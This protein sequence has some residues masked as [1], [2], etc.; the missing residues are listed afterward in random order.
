MY[1]KTLVLF[2]PD[3]VE[4][5][6]IG[7][8]ITFFEE[9]GLKIHAIKMIHATDTQVADHYS[10][11]QDK[12]FFPSLVEFLQSCPIVALV[13][14]GYQSISKVRKIC[15]ATE[16]AKAELASIRGKWAHVTYQ[17]SGSNTMQNLV[18]ASA[19]DEDA[20][21]EIGIWF[22]PDELLEYHSHDDTCFNFNS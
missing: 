5:H 10:E 4:R 16:P 13:I 12:D 17:D 6:L 3:T 19:N 22:K 2:K 15:G 21:R 11:H 9:A 18:H 1:K 7:K 20:A 8:C 14:G